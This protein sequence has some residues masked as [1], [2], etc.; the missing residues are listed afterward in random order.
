MVN[1]NDLDCLVC[2]LK[3]MCMTICAMLRPMVFSLF[4]VVL[5][6]GKGLVEQKKIR[7]ILSGAG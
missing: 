5:T 4:I 7:R 3:E 6:K 1:L 2:E